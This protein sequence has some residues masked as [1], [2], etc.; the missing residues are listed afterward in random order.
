[1]AIH[2][3]QGYERMKNALSRL[4]NILNDPG[5]LFAGNRLA[6]EQGHQAITFRSLQQR[7]PQLLESSEGDIRRF[8]TPMWVDANRS[9]RSSLL[10]SPPLDFLADPIIG[11]MMFLDSPRSELFRCEI[12]YLKKRF[13][14]SE[15]LSYLREDLVGRPRI[16]VSRYSTSHNLIHHLYH[17]AR[18]MSSTESVISEQDHVVEWGGGYG[19][20]AR[21]ITRMR[22]GSGTYT[23]IDTPLMSSLQWIFLSSIF[24]E[25]RVRFHSPGSPGEIDDGLINVVPLTS[26]GHLE[27]QA[28]IFISTWALS[29]SSSEAQ[30]LVVN[31][32]WFRA[33]R[34]LLA[35]DG[36]SHAVPYS[37][38]LGE[39]AAAAGADIEDAV[40]LPGHFYAFR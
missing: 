16:S 14:E 2:G 1:M 3:R 21:L 13:S 12:A 24:G 20:L 38:R 26:L 4:L 35:Y 40:C 30:E 32:D 15:L 18:F 5:I 23:L 39:L 27:I 7:F 19:S 9:L 8:T 22:E 36:S 29:E 10:P 25:D 11:W 17:L 6:R 37:S 28:D 34:L 33:S 31:R